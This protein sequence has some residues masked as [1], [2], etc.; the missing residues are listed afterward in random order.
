ML[1]QAYSLKS[2]LSSILPQECAK[3]AVEFEKYTCICGV[4]LF[5]ATFLQVTGLFAGMSMVQHSCRPNVE[6]LVWQRVGDP[7]PWE[8]REMI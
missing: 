1:D 7:D 3:H 4:V 6:T 5:S 2:V 8:G